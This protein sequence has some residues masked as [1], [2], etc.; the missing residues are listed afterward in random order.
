MSWLLSGDYCVNLMHFYLVC[1]NGFY[2]LYIL[3]GKTQK[4]FT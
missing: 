4:K 3:I 2:H 1:V